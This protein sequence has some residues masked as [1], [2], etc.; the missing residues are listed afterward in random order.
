M[1]KEQQGILIEK[2]V[3]S[4]SIVVALFWGVTTQIDVYAVNFVG[5]IFELL[6]L[7]MIGLV[8]FLPTLSLIMF[9]RTKF[10]IKSLYLYS[11]IVSVASLLYLFGMG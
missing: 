11:F 9:I 1:S 8:F 3:L 2:I 7:P 4:L 10:A 5:A 6:W